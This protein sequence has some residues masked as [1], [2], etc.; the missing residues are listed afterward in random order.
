M[1]CMPFVRSSVQRE[2]AMIS[3]SGTTAK[4]MSSSTPQTLC[5]LLI[6][7][8]CTGWVMSFKWKSM[9]RRDGYLT[10]ESAEVDEGDDLASVGRT[11]SGKPCH[12]L[13]QP[14][15][16]GAQKAEVSGEYV[17]LGRNSLI[18]LLW[19]IK[20]SKMECIVPHVMLTKCKKGVGLTV[21]M[22]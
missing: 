10:Q 5:S 18:E 3:A 8:G 14:T 1:D 9:L 4:C 7:S 17:A 2:L 22:L 12:G 16:V 21:V 11:K 13:L 15:D 6:S 20:I 19:P